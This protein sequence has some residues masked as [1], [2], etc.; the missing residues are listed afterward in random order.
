MHEWSTCRVQEFFNRPWHP[1][2]PFPSPPFV[3]I[4]NYSTNDYVE[5]AMLGRVLVD[6]KTRFRLSLEVLGSILTV[7]Q[8]IECLLIHRKDP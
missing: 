1:S 2:L 6:T 4:G 7:S 3:R 5:L 8:R